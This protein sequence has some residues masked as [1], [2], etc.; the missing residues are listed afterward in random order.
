MEFIARVPPGSSIESSLL[1]PIFLAGAEL[2]SESSISSCFQRLTEIQMRNRYENVGNVQKVLQE[3]W[4]PVLNGE[5]RRDWED[6]LKDWNW[7][8]SLG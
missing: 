6:V 1:Y 3:V 8:F 2:D 5:E 7:S 4:R